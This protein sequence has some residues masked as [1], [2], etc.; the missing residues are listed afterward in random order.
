MM[1]HSFEFLRIEKQADNIEQEVEFYFF[2]Y[3]ISLVL[4]NMSIISELLSIDA[5]TDP[6]MAA[7]LFGMVDGLIYHNKKIIH[8]SSEFISS[9]DNQA[10][11]ESYRKTIQYLNRINVILKPLEIHLIKASGEDPKKVKEQLESWWALAKGKR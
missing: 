11:N 3:Q 1:M 10:L 7:Y 2:V 6:N 9:S 8:Q 5:Q 4:T